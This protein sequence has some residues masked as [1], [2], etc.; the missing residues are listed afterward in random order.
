M[1]NNNKIFYESL[2]NLLIKNN[3]YCILNIFVQ[4]KE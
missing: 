1:L 3:Y 4:T 2:A